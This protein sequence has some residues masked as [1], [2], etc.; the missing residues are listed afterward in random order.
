MGLYMVAR[1]CEKLNHQVSIHSILDEGTEV[2][3]TINEFEH[4]KSVDNLK[5]HDIISI[6]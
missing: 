5:T 4:I 6:N 3:L 1:L 2:T